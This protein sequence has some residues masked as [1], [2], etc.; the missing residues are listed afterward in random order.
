MELNDEEKKLWEK[1]QKIKFQKGEDGK[2]VLTEL[3]G[4]FDKKIR[5]EALEWMFDQMVE[6]VK[7]DVFCECPHD[8]EGEDENN[9]YNFNN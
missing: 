7:K 2:D 3:K 6:K 4:K 1:I 9:N 8:N 5:K